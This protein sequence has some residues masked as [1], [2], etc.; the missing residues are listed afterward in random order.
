VNVSMK[1]H[2]ATVFLARAAW[3]SAN[4][5]QRAQWGAGTVRLGVSMGSLTR[6]RSAGDCF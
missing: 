3:L 5:P 1:D 6:G 2:R 4:V